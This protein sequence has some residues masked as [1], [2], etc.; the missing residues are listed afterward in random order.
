M[1][2]KE[3]KISFVSTMPGLEEI[4]E[5][6]PVSAQKLSPHWW[7]KM[8]HQD[9]ST[10]S[11]TAKRCPGIVDYFSN[12]Y[13]IPMWADVKLTYSK[14]SDRWSVFS[15]VNGVSNQWEGHGNGQFKNHADAHSFGKD[16]SFVFKAICPWN[17]ITSSGWSVYQ[18]PLFY[19]FDN[20]FSVMPGII[21]TDIHHIVNQQVMYFG[22]EEEVVIKRGTPFVQYVPFKRLP[23]KSEVRAASEDDL[24]KFELDRLRYFTK[25]PNTGE[26]RSIQKGRK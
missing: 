6:R 21:D 14:S 24:K 26:Y 5:C 16:V 8:P 17:I 1:F 15:G 9:L 13:I 20:R 10:N 25:F 18:L 4:E 23:V 22:D 7:K 2:S 19:H 12:G 3:P 11:T